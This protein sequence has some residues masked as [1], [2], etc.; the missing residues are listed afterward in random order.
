M[1]GGGCSATGMAEPQEV[2]GRSEDQQ[3][4]RASSCRYA[5]LFASKHGHPTGSACRINDS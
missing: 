1:G 5:A 3:S 4:N 2:T